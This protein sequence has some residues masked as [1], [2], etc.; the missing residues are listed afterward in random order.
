MITICGSNAGFRNGKS[1]R[2]RFTFPRAICIDP[3]NPSNSF[4]I[5]DRSSIRYYTGDTDTVT[6][7]AGAETFDFADGIGRDARFNSVHDLVAAPGDDHALYIT[8]SSNNRVRMID[9]STREVTTIAGSGE[10]DSDDGVGR[11]ASIDFPRRATFDRS[12]QF[13][14]IT[15]KD[16]IRRLEVNTRQ[17]TTCQWKDWATEIHPFAI[18]C[19]PTDQLIVSCIHTASIY[20]FDPGT[21]VLTLLAGGSHDTDEFVDGPGTTAR[22]CAPCDFAVVESEHCAYVVDGSDNR[23]RHITLPAQLFLTASK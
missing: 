4:Y 17:I 12:L 21:G 20:L 10:A 3:R 14:F 7:I 22:S 15:T 11:T 2:A 18:Y 8:D 1:D 6:L 9:L 23:L 5:G 13:M 16:R 19:L